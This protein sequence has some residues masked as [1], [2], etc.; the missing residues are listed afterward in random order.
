MLKSKGLHTYVLNNN[1]KSIALFGGFLIITQLIMAAIWSIVAMYL[2]AG[3][4]FGTYSAGLLRLVQNA[5]VPVLVVSLSWSALAFIYYKRLVRGLTGLVPADRNREPRLYNIVENLSISVGLSTPA[6]EISESAARNAFALG[7]SPSTA[8]I[9]VTRGLLNALDD[10]ELEAV[11]AHELTHIRNNDVR[12][13]TFA[14]IFCGIVFSVGWFI[15][16]RAREV[17]RQAKRQPK[18]NIMLA[19]FLVLFSPF[20]LLAFPLYA[21][22]T[23]LVLLFSALLGS[24]ALR[25]AISQ[26]REFVADAGA[27]ELTKNPEALIRA[28]IKIE[29]R[30]LIPDCDANV[31][32]MMISAPSKGRFSSHPTLEQRIDTLVHYAAARFNGM[33]LMPASARHL[34]SADEA[35]SSTGFSIVNMRYPAWVSKHVIV[36]PAMAM[37]ILTYFALSPDARSLLHAISPEGASLTPSMSA[38][39]DWL[40]HSNSGTFQS[41]GKIVSVSSGK[42]AVSSAP[43]GGNDFWQNFGA[44]DVRIML[45]MFMLTLPFVLGA[46]L[47][48][49]NGIGANN[50]FMRRLAGLPS[51]EMA[52]DWEE[53]TPAASQTRMH[54]TTASGQSSSMPVRPQARATFGQRR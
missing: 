36:L 51:L 38:W 11:I 39:T 1:L 9:G 19:I 7:L 29:G 35:M 43:N 26:T 41:S 13:M 48:V 12:L 49:K 40:L 24:L 17:W 2:S 20:L 15:T 5:A 50:N 6:I 53:Q 37:G 54:A 42:S 3:Q 31:R 33:K 21:I 4:G 23:F 47:L 52:S 8:T 30:S 45:V 44:N 14:T 16:Y 34:P 46:R 18:R 25:F 28:L 22:A 10:N 32:A 27:C